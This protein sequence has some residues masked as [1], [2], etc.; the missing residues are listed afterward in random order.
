MF[1]QETPLKVIKSVVDLEIV[2]IVLY[3]K[4][5]ILNSPYNYQ[6]SPINPHFEETKNHMR[7]LTNRDGAAMCK[8][9]PMIML[10]LTAG[11]ENF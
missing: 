8:Y 5:L 7:V 1:F 2:F 4:K 9:V 11:F 10:V 3:F 6:N